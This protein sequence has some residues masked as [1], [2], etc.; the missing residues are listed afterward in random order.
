MAKVKTKIHSIETITDARKIERKPA[1][2]EGIEKDKEKTLRKA[3][4]GEPG[5]SPYVIKKSKGKKD[6]IAPISTK[7]SPTRVEIEEI[8][9]EDVRELY[10]MMNQ[11][12]Q[13]MFK[14]KGVEVAS[15]IEELV[16]GV[17]ARA[18]IVLKL[19]KSWLIIIPRV[20]KFFLEQE[21]KKKAE[22]IMQLAA[23]VRKNKK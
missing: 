23:R 20:N 14:E 2:V 19:L 21:S 16:T 9:Q 17:K 6:D 1:K 15:K 4:E 11:E 10:Q 18:R 7:K 8:M 5:E 13:Q 22:E 12:E 3:R